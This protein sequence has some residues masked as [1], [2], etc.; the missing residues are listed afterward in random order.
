MVDGGAGLLR[1][2]PRRPEGSGCVGGYGATSA[3][4]SESCPS[5]QRALAGRPGG[6]G[7]EVRVA[8]EQRIVVLT[9]EDLT[10]NPDENR[11]VE[12]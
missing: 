8:T 7:F 6:C 2:D 12:T 4:G 11:E 5:G 10:L 9:P 3:C 1:P